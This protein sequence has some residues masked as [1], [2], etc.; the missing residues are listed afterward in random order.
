MK[1]NDKN[2]S[3]AV[4]AEVLGID[5]HKEIAIPKKQTQELE[6]THENGADVEADYKLSRDTLKDL[7]ATGNQAVVTLAGLADISQ[8]PRAYE[9]LATLI[10]T[11]GET[12]NSLYDIHKKTRELK[13]VSGEKKILDTG[14]G[15][16]IDKAVFCGT[17]SD[18][19]DMLK[20]Q[21]KE[22]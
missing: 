3:K 8:H 2:V 13:G 15:I 4:L 21:K 10:K 5:D 20:K 7:I 16:N 12:T 14:E 18:L 19:L 17:T 9:V 1:Q 11:V 6:P 22:E